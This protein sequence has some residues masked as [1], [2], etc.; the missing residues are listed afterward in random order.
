MPAA[1]LLER[2]A[3]LRICVPSA[4]PAPTTTSKRTVNDWPGAITPPPSF[5]G[6]SAPAPVPMRKR[7]ALAAPSN[8]AWSPS[9]GSVFVAGDAARAVDDLQRARLEARVRRD[10]VVD[11]RVVGAGASRVGRADLVAQHVAGIHVAAVEVA[12]GLLEHHLRGVDVGAEPD[13]A[14]QVAVAGGGQLDR[15]ARGRCSGRRPRARRSTPASK[16][17]WFGVVGRL[18]G[19]RVCR[20]R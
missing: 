14:G 13:D 8:S 20:G 1:S 6:T 11:A 2:I 7:T 19:H 18:A 15:R 17:S 5:G 4:A 12:D 10:R 9:L 16:P 3:V